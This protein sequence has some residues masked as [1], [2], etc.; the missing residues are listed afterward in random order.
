MGIYISLKINPEE[1]SSAQWEET[2]LESLK[3]IEEYPFIGLEVQRINGHTRYVYSHHVER[4]KLDRTKRHWHINGDSTSKKTGESFILYYDLNHYQRQERETS[5]DIL[6]DSGVTVFYSK[7]QGR[8]FHIPLLAIAM[9]F[10][11]RLT[12][13]SIVSGDIDREQ[14]IHA[15]EWADLYIEEPLQ[16]PVVTQT[17]ELYHRAS[18]LYDGVE[19]IDYLYETHRGHW[20][21]M[22][23]VIVANTYDE[24]KTWFIKNLKDYTEPTQQSVSIYSM[25]WLA[26]T[27]NLEDL[28]HMVCLD[29]RGNR[30]DP[31]KFIEHLA[32]LH[33]FTPLEERLNLDF[34]DPS[35]GMP[36]TIESLIG[37]SLFQLSTAYLQHKNYCPPEKGIHTL[38]TLFPEHG[39]EIERILSEELSER[40]RM[41]RDKCQQD[42]EEIKNKFSQPSLLPPNV[43]DLLNYETEKSRDKVQELV[44]IWSFGVKKLICNFKEFQRI[45]EDEL[46]ESI[47][48]QRL[49]QIGADKNRVTL[50]DHTWDWIDSLKD[51]ETL[52][53]L[54]A[55]LMKSEDNKEFCDFR[56]AVLE[57]PELVSKIQEYM[58]NKEVM[59]DL[60]KKIERV[61]QS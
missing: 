38:T 7:T 20:A 45:L 28:I 42:I 4:K 13:H 61:Q 60:Q 36:Q 15:K 52:K 58:K 2:Y 18:Q 39:K 49:I 9:L 56:V 17:H 37:F 23:K 3:L 50:T 46:E 19:L 59:D 30:F 5:V 26:A 40:E 29:D 31:L 32:S 33:L 27:D 54:G 34:F 8:P 10:E 41:M 21:E 55:L 44:K 22:L 25:D 14:A 53:L 57:N 11:T 43:D 6:D 48:T 35:P 24:A 12:P 47:S 16:L 51:E 1:I